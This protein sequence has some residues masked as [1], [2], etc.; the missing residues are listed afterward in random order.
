MIGDGFIDALGKEV[1]MAEARA[2]RTLQAV[3]CLVSIWAAC[4]INNS[5]GCAG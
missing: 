2:E 1:L 5:G 4:E 3:S